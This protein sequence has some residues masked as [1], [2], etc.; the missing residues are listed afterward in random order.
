MLGYI[1]ELVRP[2]MPDGECLT[3]EADFAN[4]RP[5]TKWEI[6]HGMP[7]EHVME[8]ERTIYTWITMNGHKGWQFGNTCDRAFA[9]ECAQ[10]REENERL[11]EELDYAQK[12]MESNSR[13]MLGACKLLHANGIDCGSKAICD[14]MREIREMEEA[15]REQREALESLMNEYNDRE[16]HF[17]ESRL[18]VKHEDAEILDRARKTINKYKP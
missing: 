14:A 9:D 11:K 8:A 7:P 3:S 1:V 5:P 12:G 17:G 13:I 18:W 4:M 16:A 15:N 10:L 6:L 2:Y